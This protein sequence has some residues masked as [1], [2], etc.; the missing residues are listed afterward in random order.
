MDPKMVHLNSKLAIWAL[1]LSLWA[2][3]WP[4][5]APS[6]FEPQAHLSHKLAHLSFKLVY[7][8]STLGSNGST[9]AQMGQHRAQLGWHGALMV[10]LRAQ[11]GPLRAQMG[12][13]LKW[14]WGSN[15]PNRSSNVFFWH[16]VQNY[17]GFQMIPKCYSFHIICVLNTPTT[18]FAPFLFPA[19]FFSLG[20][21]A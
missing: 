13:G 6:P 20:L 15:G 11:T 10:Q 12:L 16:S 4:I 3:N 1:I 9:W 7:L 17:K 18:S 14:A 8:S 2:P 21:S 5:W 19:T